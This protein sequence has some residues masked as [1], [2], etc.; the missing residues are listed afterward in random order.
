MRPDRPEEVIISRG[1]SCPTTLA[2]RFRAACEAWR[3][4]DEEPAAV[5]TELQALAAESLLLSEG[6]PVEVR[7]RRNGVGK[8]QQIAAEKRRD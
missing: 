4:L 8:R 7:R 2:Q 1:A 6:I 5:V 3:V